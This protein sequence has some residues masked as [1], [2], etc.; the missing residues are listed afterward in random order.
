MKL[1]TLKDIGSIDHPFSDV[2]DKEELKQEAIKWVKF[3]R[4]NMGITSRYE[5][6]AISLI[7]F[8]NIKE[9]DL[10][11]RDDSGEPK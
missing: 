7:E 2:A 8:F 10:S 11:H 3:Y 5:E 4:I 6:R 1:K 9:E